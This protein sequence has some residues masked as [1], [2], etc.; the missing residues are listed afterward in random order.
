MVEDAELLEEAMPPPPKLVTLSDFQAVDFFSPLRPSIK[1]T[2]GHFRKP[3]SVP[4]P[5]PPLTVVMLTPVSIDSS[6]LSAA[7]T[8][9]W[10]IVPDHSDLSGSWMVSERPYP[11]T[12]G[13]LRTLP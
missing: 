4:P 12:S 11:T 9:N 3:M 2:V 7:Y 8:S 10:K 5:Q 13:A 6:Q 1:S